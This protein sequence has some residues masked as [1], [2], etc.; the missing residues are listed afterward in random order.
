[1]KRPPP[2]VKGARRDAVFG[3][4]RGCHNRR[5]PPVFVRE[6]QRIVNPGATSITTFEAL[7]GRL[8]GLA[9]RMLGSRADAEDV[10]QEAYLRW[11]QAERDDIENPEAWLVTSTTRIAID[12][13]RR[14]KTEREAYVG[15]WQ[16]EPIVAQPPPDRHVDLA[17]DLSMAFLTLLE[18]A[19]AAGETEQR[20]YALSA[21]RETPFFSERERA[22]LEWTE[23][24]TR[25]ADSHVPDDVYERVSLQFD[26]AALVALTFGVVV[27]NSWN[28][29]AVSFRAPVGTYQP[30]AVAV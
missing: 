27:I 21:W 30:R 16:P 12:R 24:V 25:L 20:I 18:D 10:V 26:E 6:D 4:D 17:D 28:R 7:R 29:L 14:L 2:L 23:A 11:H 1:M 8:F 13:L 5:A 19:R 22:A 9:Y 15:P 3:R